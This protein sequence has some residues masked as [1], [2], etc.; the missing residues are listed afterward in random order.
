MIATILSNLLF[1]GIVV[2][3]VFGVPA[4]YWIKRKN[5]VLSSIVII[6]NIYWLLNFYFSYFLKD[7]STEHG[8]VILGMYLAFPILL[9]LSNGLAILIYTLATRTRGNVENQG[10]K[11]I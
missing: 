7:L 4:F 3:I 10:Q 9:L 8:G 6:I 11:N 5:K 1:F 2:S